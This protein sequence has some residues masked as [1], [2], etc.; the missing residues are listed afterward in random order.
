MMNYISLS[1]TLLNY[2]IKDWSQAD[3][4]EK[5]IHTLRLATVC[6]YDGCRIDDIIKIAEERNKTFNFLDESIDIISLKSDINKELN[7]FKRGR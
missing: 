5:Q 3:K 7:K 1:E 2:L 6:R 4:F